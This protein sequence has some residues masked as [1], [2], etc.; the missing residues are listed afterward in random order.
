MYKS[1][2]ERHIQTKKHKH[3]VAILNSD[4]DDENHDEQSS[5]EDTL[6]DTEYYHGIDLLTTCTVEQPVD[7]DTTMPDDEVLISTVQLHVVYVPFLLN[8]W[9]I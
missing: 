7:G 9:R 6:D 1:K 5:I 3:M 8:S 4:S 2:Y